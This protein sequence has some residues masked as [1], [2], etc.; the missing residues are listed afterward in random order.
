MEMFIAASI[1]SSAWAFSL[2]RCFD[3]TLTQVFNASTSS[4]EILLN[5]EIISSCFSGCHHQAIVDSCHL[6]MCETLASGKRTGICNRSIIVAGE[7]PIIRLWTIA[8]SDG[9]PEKN[10]STCSLLS[11]LI[12]SDSNTNQSRYINFNKTPWNCPV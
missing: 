1:S 7:P 10:A 12:L 8:I 11:L 4:G 2:L 9:R 6:S 5:E 3:R